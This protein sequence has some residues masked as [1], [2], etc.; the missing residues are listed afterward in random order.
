MTSTYILILLGPKWSRKETTLFLES[1]GSKE[2]DSLVQK[3][4]K[5]LRISKISH[6][7]TVFT[8]FSFNTFNPP[9]PLRIIPRAT[10]NI[11]QP[12]G[13]KDSDKMLQNINP[14]MFREF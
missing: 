8:L 11:L 13:S 14:F 2:S 6:L 9:S 12:S 10:K 1:P 4:L 5:L 7:R 3:E